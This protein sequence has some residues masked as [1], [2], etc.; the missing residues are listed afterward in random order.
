MGTK[1]DNFVRCPKSALDW[2]TRR[3]RMLE[4][5]ARHDADVIC[6]Q[7]IYI[8]LHQK[9]LTIKR[10]YLYYITISF[11]L[12]IFRKLIIFRWLKKHLLLWIMTDTFFQNQTLHAFIFLKTLD[13]MDAPSFINGTNLIFKKLTAGWLRSGVFKVTR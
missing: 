6:L 4:E 12:Q 13:L 5:I 11:L 7:V 2:K 9:I 8:N 3:F 10:E 1:N